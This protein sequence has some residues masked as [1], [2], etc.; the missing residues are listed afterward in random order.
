MLIHYKMPVLVLVPGMTSNRDMTV[1]VMDITVFMEEDQ[2]CYLK[3]VCF[4]L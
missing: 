3:A 1:Y 4:L 2:K